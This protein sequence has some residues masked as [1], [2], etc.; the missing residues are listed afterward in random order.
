MNILEILNEE[1][2]DMK[3]F[4]ELSKIY[5]PD[6]NGPKANEEKMK[7]LNQIKDEND[8]EKLEKWYNKEFDNKIKEVGQEL[9]NNPI[10]DLIKPN[11]RNKKINKRGTVLRRAEFA[12]QPF[13]SKSV[14]NQKV[15]KRR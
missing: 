13:K 8:N 14:Q 7:K 10:T 9:K 2:F 6:L 5:H 1:K 3:K 15:M 11:D 4:K 12:S